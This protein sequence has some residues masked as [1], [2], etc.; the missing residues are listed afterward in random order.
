M[1]KMLCIN[2]IHTGLSAT[3]GVSQND[4]HGAES[5]QEKIN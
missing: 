3:L 2:I 5:D 4:T 1:T